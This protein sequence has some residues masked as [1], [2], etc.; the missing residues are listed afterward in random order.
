[1]LFRSKMIWSH[2]GGTM[3]FLIDRYHA[4]SRLPHYKDLCPDGFLPV[5]RSF[6]YD[7]AQIPNRPALLA[8]KEVV[9]ADNILFGTDFPWLTSAHHVKGITGS[10]VFSEAE[11]RA[12][13]GGN[14]V[15]ILPQ[16][17]GR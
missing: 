8:L 2:G 13:D 5:A 6:Y 16:Y 7:T 10:G 9:T 15:K 12:I 11:L 3:P 4:L 1:M 17:A 14:A